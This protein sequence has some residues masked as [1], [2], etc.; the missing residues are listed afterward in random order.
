MTLTRNALAV[1]RT[2][3][4]L[5]ALVPILALG[6]TMKIPTHMGLL[7]FPEQ[8]AAL[9]LA[10][11]LAAVYLN[12][13][14]TKQ[15]P[16]WLDLCGV[17][18]SFIM[19]G[20]VFIRFQLL[21][22][23]AFLHPT[24]ATILGILVLVL[25]V[26]AVRRV[27]GWLLVGILALFIC[28]ALF[29]NHMPGMLAG[30]AMT[31][32]EVLQF[33]AA[34]SSATWGSSLQVACF[35]VAIFVLF[36]SFLIA[37]GG[38][39]FFTQLSMRVSGTGPGGAAKIAVTASALFGS[40]SGSAVSNV[41]STGVM[42]IPMMIRSGIPA[43]RAGAI[44]AVASTGGQL[45]PPIMGAAAF[46]MAEIIA[47]PY[48][49]IVIAALIPAVI[50]YLSVFLQIDFMSRRD[51]VGTLKDV[52]R[53]PMRSL[54]ARGWI[55]IIGFV[56]L[57]TGLFAMNLRAEVAAAWTIFIMLF[58]AF[59]AQ[60]I[61]P[62][63]VGAMTPKLAWD[64][65]SKTGM[66][67]AEVILV[68]TA[69]GMIVGILGTTGLGFS[70]SYLLLDLGGNSL[71]GMLLCTA[72]VAIFL[73]LGL[74]TTAVYLLLASLAAPA[75]VKS[76]IPVINAHLFVF[77]FGMLSM[78]TPPIALASFAAAAISKAGQIRTGVDSFRVGWVAYLLPFLFIYKPAL[79]MQG[80]VWGIAYAIVS[81]VIGLT[82]VVGGA[83][84]YARSPIT[85][86]LRLAWIVI[87]IA[88]ILPLSHLGGMALDGTVTVIGF[89]LLA[90]HFASLPRSRVA[91]QDAI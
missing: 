56:V 32:S 77:Y 31:V 18:A 82:L 46:L 74:P 65:L 84:G 34:D 88:S 20:W 39:E 1:Q 15:L 19:G 87:G 57:F 28:Y 58:A 71:F 37:L 83:L 61:K 64:T 25:V 43:I 41:M 12:T 23:N 80:S 30:R 6:W 75:L 10:A 5:A 36:G 2:A 27:I 14:G 53:L 50:Y 89:I 76:G 67:T 79:L 78:I 62:G 91:Q 7:I 26:D 4:I 54:L 66:A 90:W 45:M 60:V 8:I 17:L 16:W 55:S 81:S 3:L 86:P 44:E 29:G 47:V 24:E 68:T 70:L 21:S 49:Q 38:G 63:M 69:A 35:V 40:I 42:T 52:T 73:G 22:E 72:F 33:L 11:S 85:G 59:A 51:N 48:S 13:L 9:I